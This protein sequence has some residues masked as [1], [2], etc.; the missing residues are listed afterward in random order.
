MRRVSPFIHGLGKSIKTR[1]ETIPGTCRTTGPGDRHLTI[2]KDTNITAKPY[3]LTSGLSKYLN[4]SESELST[5]VV[6]S[7]RNFSYASMV[8]TKL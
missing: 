8:L 3:F 1:I 2:V 6:P 4:S 7:A 5:S